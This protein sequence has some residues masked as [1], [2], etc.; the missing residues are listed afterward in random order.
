MITAHLENNGLKLTSS[1]PFF[2][3][4]FCLPAR[5]LASLPPTCD[6]RCLSHASNDLHLLLTRLYCINQHP[7]ETGCIPTDFNP[8]DSEVLN[9]RS[10]SQT[11]HGP[12]SSVTRPLR[13]TRLITHLPFS[14][15][16]ISNL[17]KEGNNSS[18]RVSLVSLS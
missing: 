6:L 7:R 11:V 16:T 3:R 18:F 12:I 8:A 2:F 17:M 9:R 10:S 14:S 15:A 5:L 13:A 4:F 1:S